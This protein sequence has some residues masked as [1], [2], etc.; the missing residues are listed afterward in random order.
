MAQL[1]E[2]L[3]HQRPIAACTRGLPAPSLWRQRTLA[4]TCCCQ[5]AGRCWQLQGSKR[6]DLPEPTSPPGRGAQ[7]TPRAESGA[8]T[9]V[10][11]AEGSSRSLWLRTSCLVVAR[12]LV[13]QAWGW[14]HW[15]CGREEVAD[16]YKVPSP[17]P[18]AAR[19]ACRCGG[20]EGIRAMQGCI[21]N[22]RVPFFTSTSRCIAGQSGPTGSPRRRA[23]PA[24]WQ[25]FECP[26]LPGRAGRLGRSE[27]CMQR[28]LQARRET[29]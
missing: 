14:L 7:G 1:V 28:R 24:G 10:L 22:N 6:A 19:A 8:E 4:S 21:N 11:V 16:A 29:G 9:R 13:V 17:P 5:G 18:C 26:S 20:S 23:S 3:G 25:R 27:R 12:L 2:Q 15:V